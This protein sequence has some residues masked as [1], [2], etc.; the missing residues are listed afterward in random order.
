MTQYI[1]V[2][3]FDKIS[4]EE[5]TQ[6]I[7]KGAGY[8]I[9]QNKIPILKFLS[10][11]FTREHAQSL[12]DIFVEYQHMDCL[13]MLLMGHPGHA[14]YIFAS[15]I[16]SDLYNIY[17]DFLE[18]FKKS[19]VSDG[20]EFYLSEVF[21]AFLDVNVI[22]PK[23]LMG[24]IGVL[25]KNLTWSILSQP[26]LSERS[27]L[28]I[29]AATP[30]AK[31]IMIAIQDIVEDWD[32][33]D[34][35]NRTPLGY[36]AAHSDLS[37]VEFL[38]EK[39]KNYDSTEFTIDRHNLFSAAVAFNPRIEVI[40]YFVNNMNGRLAPYKMVLLDKHSL[41]AAI[42]KAT[43]TS[44]EVLQRLKLIAESITDF[45]E[46]LRVLLDAPQVFNI[47]YKNN[48]MDWIMSIPGVYFK[49][50]HV[51]KLIEHYLYFP[52][53]NFINRLKQ[54]H[55]NQNQLHQNQNQLQNHT[56]IDFWEAIK[57]GFHSSLCETNLLQE[58]IVELSSTKMPL[59]FAEHFLRRLSMHGGYDTC[60][61]CHLA[62][63]ICLKKQLQFLKSQG[64]PLNKIRL[65]IQIDTPCN[66]ME[67][68]VYHQRYTMA[69]TLVEFGISPVID[70]DKI[71]NITGISYPNRE[72][73]IIHATEYFK[74]LQNTKKNTRL[75]LDSIL[76]APPNNLNSIGGRF[77]ADA[78]DKMAYKLKE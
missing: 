16:N 62:T 23:Y 48:I 29:I 20:Q 18:C 19:L 72:K 8:H 13:Q 53:D 25:E 58:L 47:L 7:Q 74:D 30:R 50:N 3:E 55:Q 2:P 6:Y 63:K 49:T 67:Y 51:A 64:I 61:I 56:K 37:S 76:Y 59:S 46:L 17:I 9:V 40:Q 52:S 34:S 1:D 69:D 75:F 45:P 33:K 78:M 31:E 43:H 73:W 28:H 39:S 24:T 68:L 27:F 36:S 26:L 70:V 15:V 41:A 35:F 14:A 65:T 77:Y 60:T 32:L 10:R 4:E 5:F 44:E 11:Q 42:T 21:E 66:L 54:I 38:F 22:Q 57:I 71:K 12:V